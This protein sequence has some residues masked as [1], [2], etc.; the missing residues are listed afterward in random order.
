MY[1]GS[2]FTVNFGEAGQEKFIWQVSEFEGKIHTQ[3]ILTNVRRHVQMTFEPNLDSQMPS[4]RED[5]LVKIIMK[6]PKEFALS[7][8]KLD[9]FPTKNITL[10]PEIL[11]QSETRISQD[12]IHKPTQVIEKYLMDSI[13]EF[14]KKE[15]IQYLNPII[16][17]IL[18]SQVNKINKYVKVSKIQAKNFL[19]FEDLEYDFIS[20]GLT[21]IEGH[22]E[23]YDISTG[24]GK[25]SFL[26]VVCYGLFGKT[27]K[28]LKAD[29]VINR[30][31]KK[32]LETHVKIK[33]PNG[34]LLV[35]RYRKHSTFEN[36]L[37]FSINGGENI[38]GKDS[39]ETQSMIEK[40]VGMDFDMFLR[41]SYFTQFGNI[42][43]F[44]LSPDTEKKKIISEISD[45]KIYDDFV[46][47][48]KINLKDLLHGLSES[49]KS[50]MVCESEYETIRKT[51]E[52]LETKVKSFEEDRKQNIIQLENNSIAWKENLEK[53]INNLIILSNNFESNR[54]S[55][56]TD[57][58]K[59]KELWD[60]EE[61]RSVSN[62]K[63]NITNKTVLYNGY[64][65]KSSAP[66]RPDFS[67]D[68]DVI[69]NKLTIINNLE[70]QANKM[71]A[72][73]HA[74]TL[75]I[76]S[77]RSDIN[78][79]QSQESNVNCLSC[80][81]P[82]SKEHI[83]KHIKQIQLKIDDKEREI[84]ITRAKI[85]EIKESTKVKAELEA[86]L[87]EIQAKE[88]EFNSLLNNCNQFKKLTDDTLKDIESLKEALENRQ[89]NPNI[90][91]IKSIE[92]DTN[93]Y[94]PQVN[95]LRLEVD[96]NINLLRKEKE[97]ENPHCS[98]FHSYCDKL[99]IVQEKKNNLFSEK[100]LYEKKVSYNKWWKDA[101][102]IYIKSYLID[103]F[104]EQINILSNQKLSQMFD[105]ILSLHISATSDNKKVTKE[106]ITVTIYNKN[107]E[108][109]YNSLSGG[110]R[111]RICFALNLAI[112]EV[113]NINF[114]FL[115][116]DEILNGLD[117][118]GKNQVMRVFKELESKYE[119]VFVIDHTTEFKSLFTNNIMIRK[120]NGVSSVVL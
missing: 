2:P 15:L 84:Q 10:V 53:E 14:D 55:R 105:G 32:N 73:V 90:F 46:E 86:K 116:F 39:R 100:Q 103:S 109:S 118:V 41:S 58:T 13:T 26:D 96:P 66:E 119:S 80:Y 74:Q 117:E 43:K 19:S 75:S 56:L 18:L 49:D 89:Q 93:Q 31:N 28:D 6:G 34:E 59:N 1:F 115:M 110:E 22:D 16:Q 45:T 70:Q 120:S 92:Q 24:A 51:I 25:S 38:R 23:D 60:L 54:Q 27:S 3:P 91:L 35:S 83:N 63:N 21:L 95:K 87:K 68:R 82:I 4:L 12:M 40:E 47:A 78:L 52:D 61:S 5:D 97:K 114:G 48:L 71:N 79:A 85:S 29:E 113:T 99:A 72:E 67:A 98:M 7:I 101:I 64:K 9:H 17:D 42:D 33:T 8:P 111:C 88:F 57:V 62:I 20:K 69:N 81:Q 107:E 65:D 77:L 44:L 94:V 112:A 11:R 106:K 36:D 76:N 108:C 102:H 30:K 50:Y 104:I 37:F